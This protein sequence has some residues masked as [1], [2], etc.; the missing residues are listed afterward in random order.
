MASSLSTSSVD[1]DVFYVE[2]SPIDQSPPRPNTP[3]VLIST[4]VSGNDSPR[5]NFNI[6]HCIA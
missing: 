1:S 6:I 3:I 4:E 5:I 2:Q